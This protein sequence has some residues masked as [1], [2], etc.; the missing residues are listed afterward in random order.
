MEDVQTC[1]MPDDLFR[2]EKPILSSKTAILVPAV[3]DNTPDASPAH[4]PGNR[5]RRSRYFH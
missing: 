5:V 1:I 2:D 3:Y 4:T